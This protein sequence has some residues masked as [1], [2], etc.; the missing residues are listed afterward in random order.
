[1]SLITTQTV[2]NVTSLVSVPDAVLKQ[3]F[4]GSFGWKT[5]S[6]L[7]DKYIQAVG[8]PDQYLTAKKNAFQAANDAAQTRYVD[9]F[10]DLYNNGGLS[11]DDAERLAC[12]GAELDYETRKAIVESTYPNVFDTAAVDVGVQKK[13][14]G[15]SVVKVKVKKEK[16]EKK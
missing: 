10:K 5:E 16:V 13:F 2:N 6:K 12:K 4:A 3:K 15:N 1:M 7:Y 14:S 8:T 9:T 11:E